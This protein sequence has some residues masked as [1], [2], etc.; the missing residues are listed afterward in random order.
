MN[1]M[2]IYDYNCIF[3]SIFNLHSFHRY[4]RFKCDISVVAWYSNLYD[5][6]NYGKNIQD[7]SNEHA[8]NIASVKEWCKMRDRVMYNRELSP[9]EANTL[10]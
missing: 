7:L 9:L 4:I 3:Y 2:N 10:I 1:Y 8:S 5:V 6:M